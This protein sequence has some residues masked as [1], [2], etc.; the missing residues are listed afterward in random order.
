M[1]SDSSSQEK[2]SF[3]LKAAAWGGL[4]FLH[5]PI[6]IIFMYAFNTEDAAFSFPPQGFT[7]HWF[8]VAFGRQDVLESITLSLK[9]ACIATL[10]AMLLGTLAAA[11]LYRRDF[12]GKEGI[13]LMLIL[14][15]A[16]PGIITG[17]ALL[18]AFK[19]LGIEPGFLTIVIG[20]ATFCVVIVYNNVIARFRRTSHSLIEASMDLGADGWQ[21]F[22][23]VILPNLGSA[24]LAG[25]MLAFALSFDEII[26]TT[27]TAGHERT[28]PIWLL[29]QLT[30][31]RD[32]PVTNVV[33]MLVMLVTMLPILGAYYLTKG[34]E[35]VAGSGK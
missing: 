4:V 5:F 16:L 30:R 11:A 12:F 31:P 26:V 18:S 15:I 32:V 25:G 28:L 9:I 6:L 24:L 3:G 14:P 2:A 13:S 22:R 8:S 21:T 29:N 20:H 23:Y 35:G 17:I 10:I 1:H 33:A 34:G 19:T 7:L 27:F